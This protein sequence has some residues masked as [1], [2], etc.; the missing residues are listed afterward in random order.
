LYTPGVQLRQALLCI[1]FFVLSLIAFPTSQSAAVE[2]GRDVI[3]VVADYLNLPDVTDPRL[4]NISRMISQGA[5]GLI[6]PS[7]YGT[8]TEEAVYASLAAGAN[9]RGAGSLGEAYSVDELVEAENDTAGNVYARRSGETVFSDR[10]VHLGIPALMRANEKNDRSDLVGQLGSCLR[11]AGKMTAVFGNCDGSDCLKR[12]AVVVAA[13]STG[14]VPLGDVS[15]A[16]LRQEV[17]S[18]AGWVTD[19]GKVLAGVEGAIGRASFI[20]VDFGD[21]T[22]L[23]AARHE[24][25]PQ[26]YEKYRVQTLERLIKK[27]RCPADTCILHSGRRTCLDL[28]TAYADRF[29]WCRG[30]RACDVRYDPKGWCGDRGRYSSYCA[31]IHWC[32]TASHNVR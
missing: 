19:T 16:M 22:R 3:L 26:A 8:K 27:I 6:S 24:L 14:K 12:S 15:K 29:L 13:D 11:E 10:V 9:I 5:S 20:V 18:P 2:S 17:M 1:I 28:A 32:I 21:T 31:S 30:I 4:G 7:A 25:S 23:S